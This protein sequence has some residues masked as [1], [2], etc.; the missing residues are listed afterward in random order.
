MTDSISGR[1][2]LVADIGGTNTR[3]ALSDG[4]TLLA[5]TI[6][7]FPNRDF[8][9]LTNVLQHFLKDQGGVKCDSACIAVA[10]PVRDGVARLTNLDWDIDTATLTKA[11]GAKSVAI[12]NDLQAQGHGLDQLGQD[13]LSQII[14]GPDSG[15]NAT[16]LVVGIGTGFNAAVVL[17]SDQRTIIPPS[18]CGHT[19]MP[20]RTAADLDLCQFARNGDDFPDIDSLLSGR[21]LERIYR[22]HGSKSGDPA[23]LSAAQIMDGVA[24]GS[25]PLC[26]AT[27]Q[28]FSTL[29][30]ATVGDLALTHL[31][32]GGIY[33]AGGVA[34][35]F[36]PYLDRYGFTHAFHDK[37]RFGSF[38]DNFS[39]RVIEDDWAALIG[40]AHYM[41]VPTGQ[42]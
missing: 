36:T 14:P 40:C 33:L 42:T 17:Q 11:T 25:D 10:G 15:K 32:F 39:V 16:R 7:R 13:K 1:Y 22:W 12:L 9:G 2:N 30:G 4:N 37:G 19:N 23:P 31:P 18:E 27:A 28:T 6:T 35:A 34:R 24:A 3:V 26:N 5:D 41:S 8:T 29:L 38:M 20:I 21:G